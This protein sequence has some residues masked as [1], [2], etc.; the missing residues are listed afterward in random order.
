MHSY[1][2]CQCLFVVAVGSDLFGDLEWR[3]LRW[4]LPWGG[5]SVAL[6]V[7]TVFKERARSVVDVGMLSHKSGICRMESGCGYSRVGCW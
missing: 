7:Q 4:L 3:V 5:M 6:Q 1:E 2:V